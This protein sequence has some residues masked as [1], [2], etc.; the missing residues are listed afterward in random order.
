MAATTTEGTGKGSVTIV[1]KPIL[2]GDV[3]ASN[4]DRLVEW[5]TKDLNIKAPNGT[6]DRIDG[7]DVT[8]VAGDGYL[9]AGSSSGADGG[10][11]LIQA[12]M[13]HGDGDSGNVVIRGGDSSTDFAN[14]DAGDVLIYGGIA[15][16]NGDSDGGD[17]RLEAGDGN[18]SG[19]A[20]EI[21][22]TAGDSGENSESNGGNIYIDAGNTADGDGGD[23]RIAAGFSSSNG[24]GGDVILTGGSGTSNGKVVVESMLRL[25]VFANVTQRDSAAGTPTSGMICYLNDSNTLQIYVNNAWRTIDNSAIV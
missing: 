3:E 19:E 13:Q 2:N 9:G 24:D 8:I 12:G 10:D 25:P 4:L 17:I 11:I 1:K 22:I 6:S 5:S 7:Y 18:D 16:G 20:G 23:V 21:H 15:N 14:S